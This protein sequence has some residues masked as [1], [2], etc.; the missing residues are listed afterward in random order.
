[1]L[2]YVD[3]DYR[4]DGSART[5]AM[6]FEAWSD[7]QETKLILHTTPQVAAYQPRAF[8]LRELPCL[9]PVL[10]PLADQLEV[11]VVDGYVT[12]DAAGQPGL[13]W[14]LFEALGQH[15]AVIGV[16]KTAF[17]GSP[18]ALPVQ[19]GNS[20]RPLFVTAAGISALRAASLI[21]QMAGPHRFPSLLKRV[22]QACGTSH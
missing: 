17:R 22:D 15:V 5:A 16:G 21:K 20:Q 18:H 13:G 2:A 14:H 9:L 4:S 11:V 19:R 12:L 6:L 8:Y 7:A 10:G 3:V 1:M